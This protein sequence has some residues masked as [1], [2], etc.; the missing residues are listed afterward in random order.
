VKPDP[1]VLGALQVTH[2]LEATASEKWHKQEHA[3][4]NTLKKYP[5]LKRFFDRRHKEAYCRQHDLRKQMMRI[6][7]SVETNLG[8]TSYTEDPQEAFEVACNLLDKLMAAYQV[9]R[10]TAKEAGDTD[11]REAFHG[12]IHDLKKIYQMGEQKLQQIEDLGLPAFLAAQ[13]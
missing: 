12:Y 7:G 10:D 13:L 11:T 4:K 9:I 5:G 8:D 3:F 6:G 1:E 2:D